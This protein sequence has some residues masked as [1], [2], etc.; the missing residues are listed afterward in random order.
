MTQSITIGILSIQG[1]IEENASAI[2]DSMEELGIDGN[3]MFL[4]D[5]N[6]IDLIDGLIIPGG[7][8]TVMGTLLFLNEDYKELLRNKIA[9]GLPVLGTCAGLIMLSKHA[10]DKRV[11]ETKQQLLE[12]LDATIERN[13]FGRQF[14]SFESQLTVPILGSE[15]FKGVFIRGPII[16]EVGNEVEI[17][18]KIDEKI[19]AIKQKNIL[20]T[21]FHP[22][23]AS[24]NRF[25]KLLINMS[26]LYNRFKEAR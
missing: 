4:R 15:T 21:S 13:A 7:E 22:E 12:L 5:V 18:S 11:G 14:E 8:S 24:D 6:S 2:R 3:I 1:D 10:Y 17:L 19:V 9:T 23:L 26:I 20:G 25:H 16:T